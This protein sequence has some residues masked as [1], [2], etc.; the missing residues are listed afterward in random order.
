MTPLAMEML[1]WFHTRSFLAGP[2]PNIE[3]EPQQ[4]IVAWFLRAGIIEQVESIRDTYTATSK[5]S[6]WLAR[7]LQ[8]PI[9]DEPS[10]ATP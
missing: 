6:E 7:A 2:F 4:E 1:I 5:G 9:P 3:R 10:P 8:T